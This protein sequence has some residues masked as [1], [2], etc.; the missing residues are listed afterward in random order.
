MSVLKF[1]IQ[2]PKFSYTFLLWM[3]TASHIPCFSFSPKTLLKENKN[4]N[5]QFKFWKTNFVI[6]FFSIIF[7]GK[8]IIFLSPSKKKE[9]EGL[10]GG[11]LPCHKYS[12]HVAPFVLGMVFV[13]AQSFIVMLKYY[14]H[15]RDKLVTK[16][17]R[18]WWKMIIFW[19]LVGWEPMGESLERTSLIF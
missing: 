19:H 5:N 4:T 3:L 13:E 10:L 6:F 7:Y 8:L 17:K 12:F 18:Y 1:F 9:K 14:I 16:I 2:K 11:I 15:G